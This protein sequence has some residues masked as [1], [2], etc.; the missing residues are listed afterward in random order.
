MDHERLI[1]GLI[2]MIQKEELVQRNLST[3]LASNKGV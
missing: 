2:I 1:L 3:S